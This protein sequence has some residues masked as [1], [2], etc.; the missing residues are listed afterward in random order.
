MR[1]IAVIWNEA[2]RAHL[3]LSA[4]QVFLEKAPWCGVFC[5]V[6][7]H[8]LSPGIYILSPAT[9]YAGF[10]GT[11][12]RPSPYATTVPTIS[13][14]TKVLKKRRKLPLPF[15]RTRW[16]WTVDCVWEMER[17]KEREYQSVSVYAC[18][19]VCVCASASEWMY[20]YVREFVS[21]LC[22]LR[23]W[24][25]AQKWRAALFHTFKKRT[26]LSINNWVAQCHARSL[27]VF[28]QVNLLRIFNFD[29]NQV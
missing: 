24:V 9:K 10:Y 12:C 25:Q 11:Y 8:I 19:R 29:K 15:E 5:R 13:K 17:K 20:E 3:E 22:Q 1:A 21:L 18:V 16:A 14:A 26:E 7:R 23:K 4:R 28:K 27:H 2:L 6:L